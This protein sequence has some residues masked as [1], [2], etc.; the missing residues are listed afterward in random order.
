MDEIEEAFDPPMLDVAV[1]VNHT[2]YLVTKIL[3]VRCWLKERMSPKTIIPIAIH[4]MARLPYVWIR[5][6][7]MKSHK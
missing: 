4:G 6:M 7:Y 2:M 5:S 1:M 3:T